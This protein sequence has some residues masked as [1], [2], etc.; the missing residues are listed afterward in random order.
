MSGA[1]VTG[2]NNAKLMRS[3][4][5]QTKSGQPI[6]VQFFSPNTRAEPRKLT[7]AAGQQV[8][9]GY[10]SL[11]VDG[12]AVSYND[13]VYWSHSASHWKLTF[14]SPSSG[15]RRELILYPIDKDKGPLPSDLTELIELRLARLVKDRLGCTTERALRLTTKEASEGELQEALVTAEGARS[16]DRQL[17]K[18]PDDDTGGVIL[19]ED[20]HL[21]ENT[22]STPM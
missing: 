12:R 3:H 7:A 4:K 15:K 14:I 18:S 6:E 11:T 13:V 16:V 10:E 8:F 22:T 21:V 5:M 1:S 20:E 2:G 19:E 9:F 17:G